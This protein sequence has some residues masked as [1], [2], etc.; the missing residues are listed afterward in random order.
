MQTAAKMYLMPCNLDAMQ[1]Q[2]RLEEKIATSN[3]DLDNEELR[4]VSKELTR[5]GADATYSL[6]ILTTSPLLDAV[7]CC[8]H[9]RAAHRPHHRHRGFNSA[10]P[11]DLSGKL[12]DPARARCGGVVAD[13]GGARGAKGEASG[14]T[15]H[16]CDL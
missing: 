4:L 8:E 11:L 7:E 9:Q 16:V 3:R 1:E 14:N 15:E 2:R 6:N 5:E 13:E 12:H 10:R